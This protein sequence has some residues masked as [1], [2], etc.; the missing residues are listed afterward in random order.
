MGLGE[1]AEGEDV[2]LGVAR[3][4]GGLREALL[5]GVGDLVVARREVVGIAPGEDRAED[6][7][8]AFRG[9]PGGHDDRPGHDLAE[10]VVPDGHVG[11]VQVDGGEG[12]VS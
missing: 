10:G 12:D 4:L 2:A 1:G 6:L 3:Q 7:P 8:G 9:D 5:E 11:G